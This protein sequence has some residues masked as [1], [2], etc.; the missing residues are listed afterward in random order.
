M[1]GIA[2]PHPVLSTELS[3]VTTSRAGSSHW[4]VTIPQGI[5]HLARLE[6]QTDI[7]NTPMNL[8][9]QTSLF[10]GSRVVGQR[11]F[12]Y[13]HPPD[14]LLDQAAGLLK[15]AERFYSHRIELSAQLE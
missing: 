13:P 6:M 3:F 8:Q 10:R 15:G 1:L 11:I 9:D 5:L 2:Y 4:S 12:L 7:A 14:A